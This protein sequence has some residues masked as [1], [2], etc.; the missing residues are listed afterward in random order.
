MGFDPVTMF[1]ASTA[2]QVG[3]GVMDYMEHK[4]ADKA[5][6]SAA[7]QEAAIMEQ[8]AARQATEEKRAGNEAAARQRMLFLSS[9]VDLSGS[10]LLEVQRTVRQG[11]QNA[12]T[13]M[14]NAASRADLLRK[15]GG[16]GRASLVGS[17]LQTG[18]N[19]MGNYMNYSLLKKQ[20]IPATPSTSGVQLPLRPPG[21]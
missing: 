15:Q 20:L 6:K 1:I 11:N 16:L 8:D 18:S 10:P 12:E 14:G 21:R 7:N 17:A 13:V 9:G 3:S 19:V 4:K 2:L 5:A